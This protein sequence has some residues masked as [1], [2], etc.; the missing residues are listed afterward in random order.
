MSDDEKLEL[1]SDIKIHFKFISK[2]D[3]IPMNDIG[4]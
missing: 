2:K 1:L 4:A 3:K